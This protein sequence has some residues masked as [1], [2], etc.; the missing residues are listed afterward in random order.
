MI[1][2]IVS[3]A[4]FI[5]LTLNLFVLILLGFFFKEFKLQAEEL[6]R[7]FTN[8]DHIFE[9]TRIS[10]I[11]ETLDPFYKMNVDKRSHYFPAVSHVNFK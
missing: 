11:G 10:K 2:C 9:H 1:I 5:E 7:W 4:G 8:I 3:L 6:K